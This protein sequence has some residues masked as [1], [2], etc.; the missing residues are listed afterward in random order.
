MPV[1]EEEALLS[2]LPHLLVQ[3]ELRAPAPRP[4]KHETAL[5]RVLVIS[6]DVFGATG[7]ARPLV[8]RKAPRGR[9]GGDGPPHLR[10]FYFPPSRETLPFIASSVHPPPK[11]PPQLAAPV[12]VGFRI[13]TAPPADTL[14]LLTNDDRLHQSSFFSPCPFCYFRRD[15]PYV[16]SV[17]VE[18]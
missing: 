11:W 13:T 10:V 14:L 9:R 3:G 2:S 7:R 4:G 5:G 8:P 15:L 17:S 12:V 6:S 1:R 16:R 18:N